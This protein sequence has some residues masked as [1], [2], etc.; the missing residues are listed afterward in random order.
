MLVC[1]CSLHQ[2]LPHV[3]NCTLC[4]RCVVNEPAQQMHVRTEE[5][6][7]QHFKPLD[8]AEKQVKPICEECQGCT[9][10][11]MVLVSWH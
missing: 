3:S 8:V 11:L 2:D 10:Q 1:C 6:G 7:V 9:H 4:M 5:L